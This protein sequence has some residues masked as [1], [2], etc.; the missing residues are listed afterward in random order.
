MGTT[1][2]ELDGDSLS[3]LSSAIQGS[4]RVGTVDG[5]NP[6]FVFVL[7]LGGKV[8]VTRMENMIMSEGD[9]SVWFIET[10]GLS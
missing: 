1:S 8:S 6:I 7:L 10:D 2:S 4:E 9:P 3:G 5:E